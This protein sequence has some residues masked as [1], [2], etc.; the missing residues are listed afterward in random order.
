MSFLAFMSFADRSIMAVALE[1]VKQAFRLTD[2][3]AGLLGSLTVAGISILTLPCAIFGDRWSRRKMVTLMAVIWSFFTFTTG[4]ARQFSV[5]L[6]SRFMVGAGEAGYL[7]AG[8]TWLSASFP[9]EKRAMI[10][11]VFITFSQL[12]AAAG[13]IIGGV[14]ISL[15]KDW[16]TPFF[17]F[18]IPGFI[19]GI[20]AFF[21]KDYKAVKEENEAVLSLAYF[22]NWG[23][24]FKVKS[25]WLNTATSLFLYFVLIPTTIWFPTLL[26]RAYHMDSKQAGLTHGLLMFIV[27]LAPLGGFLADR[28]QKRHR[29]G[30]PYFIA[31]G[32]AFGILIKFAAFLNVGEALPFFLSLFAI[33]SAFFS[34]IIPI[35]LTITND[36]ITPGLRS[37]TV[38][39]YNFIAQIIGS[40]GGTIFVG[41]VSDRLGGG[42]Y[43]LQ[44]GIIATLPV[45]SLAIVT[46]L[47][48]SKYYW[49]DSAQISDELLAEK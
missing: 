37:T 5:L 34:L 14:L 43:G 29:C 3:Q 8:S 1:P 10:M 44:W 9:K 39:L 35:G 11:S 16:R 24:I 12:G 31:L 28:W 38:G 27:M 41:A 2:Y 23:T 20:M 46:S 33:G 17:V 15:T 47:I 42:D 49:K 6:L 32:A 18:A 36:V 22:K 21:L 13:L 45:A 19:F 7:P 30:R 25:F 48:M 26:M 4:L 40:T